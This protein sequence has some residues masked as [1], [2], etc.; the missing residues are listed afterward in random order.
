MT[1]IFF[2]QDKLDWSAYIRGQQRGQGIGDE[3]DAPKIFRGTRYT[4]GYGSIR[5]V[6]GSVGRFLMPIASNIMQSAKK[7]A[8][9]SLGTAVA[10]ISEGK[11]IG[12]T[13]KEQATGAAQRL[14]SRM[15]QCGK[16][17]R[18]VID[19]KLLDVSNGSNGSNGRRKR[20]GYLDFN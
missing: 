6:L 15:Q 12:E 7:E 8:L 19:G 17:K 3:I 16:G 4:R 1:H 5:N 11:E 18:K 13:L 14:G 9:S 10:D 2:D 20:L